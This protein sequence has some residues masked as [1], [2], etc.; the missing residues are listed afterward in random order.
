[1]GTRAASAAGSGSARPSRPLVIAHRGA[2][3][4]RPENTLSAF[5]LAID[6]RADMIETDLRLS[7]DGAIV[8]RHDPD[9]ASLGLHREVCETDLAQIRSLDAGGGE[10][11]P[12]LDEVLDRFGAQIA[13][14][15]EI[16]T[17]SK[18][19]Y[20]GLEAAALRA[21][22]QRGLLASTLFSSFSDGILE[23][24]RAL[25]SKV[26][27]AVLVSRRRSRGV[28]ER[29]RAVEA[30]ALNPSFGL[31]NADF[32]DLAHADGLAVYP[33]T[34]DALSDMRRCLRVGADGLFT[35]YPDRLRGMLDASLPK[36][37]PSFD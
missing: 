33:Y 34:V 8:I 25:S 21:V 1:M 36:D 4:A 3:A 6:Q 18:S 19:A 12:T 10:K 7:R 32:I 11:V 9:L 2:S 15:L 31:V 20:P 13:F 30:E 27:L 16:K 35:N 37:E 24:L 22:E 23:Q 17:G 5:Q 26:R 28:L 14:N 29:T